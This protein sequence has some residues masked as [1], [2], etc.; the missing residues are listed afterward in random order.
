[1][2]VERIQCLIRL[3]QDG[4]TDLTQVVKAGPSAVLAT[5]IPLLRMRHDVADGLLEEECCISLAK[6]VGEVEIS[7]VAEFERLK[8]RY[9]ETVSTVYPQGRMMPLTLADC[10]LPNGCHGPVEKKATKAHT[11]KGLRAQL[12]EAGVTVPAGNLSVDDLMAL[13]VENG[14]VAAA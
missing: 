8:N 6:V 10:E 7:K 4:K 14:L 11:A 12:K 13:I 2:I 1:M 9:G 5:E 3:N